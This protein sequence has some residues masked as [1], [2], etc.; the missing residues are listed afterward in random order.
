MQN[1][2]TSLTLEDIDNFDIEAYYA[3]KKL[4]HDR[5]WT[6][7]II[8]ILWGRRSG[9]ELRQLYRDLWSIRNP[10]G[11]PM[12]REFEATIRSAINHHTSQSSRWNGKREDDLFY[13]PN[14]RS[15]WAVHRDRAVAWL[16]KHNRPDA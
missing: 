12:P 10:P 14:G 11:L 7:D 5:P 13:S 16:G 1:Q 3:K 6:Y 2:K 9:V 8:R 15:T 4:R